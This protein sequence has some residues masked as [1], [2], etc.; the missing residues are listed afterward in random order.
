MKDEFY[1]SNHC[2]YSQNVIQFISRNNLI[3]R[4]S[5]ICI[6]NRKQDL[7]RNYTYIVLENGQTIPLPP[8]IQ[9]V[10]SLLL[11][12]K[13]YTVLLGSEQIITHFQ[14]THSISSPALIKNGEP[15]SFEFTG[16]GLSDYSGSSSQNYALI[17]SNMHIHAPDDNYK[18]DKLSTDVTVAKIVQQRNNL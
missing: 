6:D 12:S 14:N 16:S 5:C 3:D 9:S 8:S 17:D 15:I 4:I 7:S 18:A 10:P 2:Q 11:K 13:N 1:Y